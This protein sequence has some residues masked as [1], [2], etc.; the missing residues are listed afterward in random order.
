MK[1][2]PTG[3]NSPRRTACYEGKTKLLEGEYWLPKSQPL[4]FFTGMILAP[5]GG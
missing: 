4:G 5:S 1:P 3:T 2:N